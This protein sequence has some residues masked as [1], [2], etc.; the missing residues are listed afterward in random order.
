MDHLDRAYDSDIGG[1]T[2]FIHGFQNVLPL[3]LSCRQ[4][5][6][7][8]I[9]IF[10]GQNVFTVSRALHRHDYDCITWGGSLN[11]SQYHPLIYTPIWFSAVGSHFSLLKK[12]V[13]DTDALCPTT[14][15]WSEKAIDILPLVL[16]LWKQPGLVRSLLF[17]GTGTLSTKHKNAIIDEALTSGHPTDS[18]RLLHDIVH[19]IVVKDVLELKRY[20]YSS[21]LLSSVYI[22]SS[23]N[24]LTVNYKST[25]TT[26]NVLYSRFLVTQNDWALKFNEDKRTSGIS[27]LASAARAKVYELACF[28]PSGMVFDLDQHVVCGFDMSL[29]HTNTTMRYTAEDIIVPHTCSVTLK[30]TSDK[31][32]SDFDHFSL[33]H[34]L[35]RAPG[36]EFN[37]FHEFVCQGLKDHPSTTIVLNFNIPSATTLDHLRINIRGLVDFLCYDKFPPQATIRFVLACPNSDVTQEEHAVIYLADL[38]KRVFLLLSDFLGHWP[39]NTKWEPRDSLPDIWISGRGAIINASYPESAKA[40]AVSVDNRHGSLTDRE[41]HYR[42]YRMALMDRKQPDLWSELSMTSEGK[43]LSEMW[44]L[45]RY[46]YWGD[47]DNRREYAGSGNCFLA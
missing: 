29:F 47:Y 31:V 11:R 7:V 30:M 16:C 38:E 46:H 8:S 35:F 33:L 36:V 23:F 24:A 2:E 22:S 40:P 12:V 27:R 44:G 20:T 9:S 10:Y 19:A 14:C 41:V 3:F 21:R 39:G 34:D 6:H 17:A 37:L 1:A 13:I 42:G 15:S 32:A 4:I 26:G 28:A 5:Y 18:A 43:E 25:T 45:L